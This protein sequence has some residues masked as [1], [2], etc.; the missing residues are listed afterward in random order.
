MERIRMENGKKM[1][2]ILRVVGP[3]G[4]TIEKE[5]QWDFAVYIEDEDDESI[6][7]EMCEKKDYKAI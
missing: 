4:A 6:L 2:E 7:I 5:G 1:E 3:A